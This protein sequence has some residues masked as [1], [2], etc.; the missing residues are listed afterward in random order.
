MLTARGIE[1]LRFRVSQ[2]VAEA[3]LVG[4]FGE[5]T[6]QLV[7]S[8]L[9]PACGYDKWTR[10]RALTAYYFRD[11]FVGYVYRGSPGAPVLTAPRGIRVGLPLARAEALGGA[12]FHRSFSE[13][14]SW[15]LLTPTGKVDGLLTA[16][17]PRGS[18]ED[19]A[20]GSLGCQMLPG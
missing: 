20:G 17:P 9:P 11:R 18:V 16:V 13:G 12:A 3:T 1:P 15:T 8:H 10:W 2:G 19:I 6:R 14:G 4:W 5:P 7:P